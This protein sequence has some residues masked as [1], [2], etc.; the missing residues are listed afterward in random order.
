MGSATVT[1]N[2]KTGVKI[3]RK[4]MGG[5][6]RGDGAI[7]V[8]SIKALAEK[9][10]TAIVRRPNN[11]AFSDTRTDNAI[12]MQTVNG[13]VSHSIA[14]ISMVEDSVRSFNCKANVTGTLNVSTALIYVFP[15]LRMLGADP[16]K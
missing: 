6:D 4:A 12:P 1:V 15:A 16:R 10:K 11:L 2:D 13:P 14:K 9:L 3:Y 7:N 5:M 8:E